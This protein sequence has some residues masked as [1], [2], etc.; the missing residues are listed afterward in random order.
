MSH[1]I[2]ISTLLLVLIQFVIRV[3]VPVKKSKQ[4]DRPSAL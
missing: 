4:C 2:F 3:R 1:L